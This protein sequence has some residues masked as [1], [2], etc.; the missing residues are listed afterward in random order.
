MVA[1]FAMV[2]NEIIRNGLPEP[3]EQAGAPEGLQILALGLATL[4]EEG[5]GMPAGGFLGDEDARFVASTLYGD[6]RPGS[7]D[8]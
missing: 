8:R 1:S 5:Q 7:L 4:V 2:G 6:E 3:T